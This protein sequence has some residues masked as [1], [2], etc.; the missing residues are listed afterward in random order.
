VSQVEGAH[1]HDISCFV[2]DVSIR[3]E[4]LW[5]TACLATIG[6]LWFGWRTFR[7]HRCLSRFNRGLCPH[8]KYPLLSGELV[9]CPECGLRILHEGT[10]RHSLAAGLESE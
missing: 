10:P 9:T 5:S 6:M 2:G 1:P 7:T 3:R 8:C 4:L